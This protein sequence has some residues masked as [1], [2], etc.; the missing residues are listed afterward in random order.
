MLPK[1]S[2]LHDEGR[3]IFF[4]ATN[5]QEKWDAAIKRSGRFDLL[6]CVGP[7]SWQRKLEGIELFL[8][9]GVPAEQAQE[10]RASLDRLA[11]SGSELV[12]LLDLFTFGEMKAFL[13]ALSWGHQSIC[14]GIRSMSQAEFASR[15]RGFAKYI[16]LRPGDPRSPIDQYV[17]DRNESRI[18]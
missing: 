17:R 18:Q 2:Q 14:D 6:I 11:G 9:K 8:P 16:T 1:L 10:A 4:M 15:V 7:P 13:A 5:Y 3:V 12:D